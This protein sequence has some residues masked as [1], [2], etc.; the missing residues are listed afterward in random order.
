MP[1]T[2]ASGL[3][4]PEGLA[5][6]GNDLFW[7]DFQPDT[8]GGIFG[9]AISDGTPVLLTASVNY[10]FRIA[11]DDTHVYWTDEGTLG[12]PDGA[13]QRMPVGGGTPEIIADE[14]PTPRGLVLDI[15]NGRATSVFW[16]IFDQSGTVMRAEVEGGGSIGAVQTLVTSQSLPN[17]VTLDE[18]YIYWTNRGDGTVMRLPKDASPGATPFKLAEN[19]RSPGEIAVDGDFIYWVNEGTSAQMQL[20]GSVVRLDKPL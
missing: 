6:S 16:T 17:H 14:L 10:P 5:V 20:D 15:N 19:Q 9:A 13:V 4:L 11:M 12:S 18:V 7:T 8:V 2:I 3:A 1:Q